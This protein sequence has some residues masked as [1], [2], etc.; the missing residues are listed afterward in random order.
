[1]ESLQSIEQKKTLPFFATFVFDR[2]DDSIVS[3]N[4][5]KGDFNAESMQQ[6][7]VLLGD[8]SGIHFAS[9]PGEDHETMRK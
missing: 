5:E 9:L 4:I 3:D 1:M 8:H 7:F 6:S 2:R